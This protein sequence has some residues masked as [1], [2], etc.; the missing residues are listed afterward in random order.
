[1]D[2]EKTGLDV[3]SRF[4]VIS[5]LVI[6]ELIAMTFVSR[7]LYEVA[8]KSVDWKD[9]STGAII[10]TGALTW[11]PEGELANGEAILVSTYTALLRLILTPEGG[12]DAVCCEARFY[13]LRGVRRPGSQD[14]RGRTTL[15]ALEDEGFDASHCVYLAGSDDRFLTKQCWERTAGGGG[16]QLL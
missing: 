2:V 8:W 1:L 13:A 5:G 9:C 14:I 4:T 15:I 10:S 12:S 16:I 11:Y 6:P 7:V 3:S